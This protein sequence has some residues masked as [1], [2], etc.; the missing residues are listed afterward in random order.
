MITEIAG[1]II[2]LVVSFVVTHYSY[3]TTQMLVFM[4]LVSSLICTYF[5]LLPYWTYFVDLGLLGILIFQEWVS[6][7]K[8]D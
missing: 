2:C 6:S 8:G 4:L 5:N 1:L 7:R 3:N